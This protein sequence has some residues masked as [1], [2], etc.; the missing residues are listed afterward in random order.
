MGTASPELLFGTIEGSKQGEQQTLDMSSETGTGNGH[1]D[2]R[3]R[4][5][6]R[7]CVASI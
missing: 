2:R 5:A 4:A 6:R 1:G 7:E 3:Q